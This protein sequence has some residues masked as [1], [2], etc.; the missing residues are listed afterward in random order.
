MGKMNF[1]TIENEREKMLAAI[2]INVTIS[3]QLSS[4]K[5]L[6]FCTEISVIP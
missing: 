3:M 4:H 2:K 5:D 6:K 1:E